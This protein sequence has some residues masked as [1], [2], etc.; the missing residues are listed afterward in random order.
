MRKLL[1]SALLAS[2]VAY[3]APTAQAHCHHVTPY[4]PWCWVGEVG[5][6]ADPIICPILAGLAST[7]PSNG[8]LAAILYIESTSG[9]SDGGDTYVAGSLFWD[10]PPY[11]M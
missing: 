9:N 8:P 7:F 2:S 4:Y 3:G 6:E 11:D 5:G 10:C 1:V